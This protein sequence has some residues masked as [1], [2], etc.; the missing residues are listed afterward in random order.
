MSE[1]TPRARR[2]DAQ[3]NH[4]ALLTAAVRLFAE[5]GSDV[6]Y[7]E[8]AHRAGV[9]RATLYRHF[10]TREDLLAAILDA[11]LDDLQLTSERLPDDPSRFLA[12]FRACLELQEHTLPFIDCVT[13]A[14]PPPT[15]ERLRARLE[16]L[17]APPL[18]EAQANGIVRTDLAASDVRILLLMLSSVARRSPL[19]DDR[20]RAIELTEAMLRP[21]G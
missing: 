13:R 19:G 18:R 8:I 12:L 9:G 17:F 5:R 11:I 2:S 16:A 14:T 15:L 7:E 1:I 4:T 20:A 21:D 6:A 10:P 3:A